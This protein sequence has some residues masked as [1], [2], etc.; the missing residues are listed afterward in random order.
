M[1]LSKTGLYRLVS[2]T[3]LSKKRLIPSLALV[4]SEKEKIGPLS[5]FH[6]GREDWGWMMI[7]FPKF[8]SIVTEIISG[9]RIS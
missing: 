8:R 7:M 5:R 6:V 9:V 3:V 1:R 2:V 4:L